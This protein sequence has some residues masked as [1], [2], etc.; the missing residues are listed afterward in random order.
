MVIPDKSKSIKEGVI[1][2]WAKKSSN[3]YEQ[4]WSA[5]CAYYGIDPKV[6]FEELS[7]E[8]SRTCCC[9]VAMSAFRF[10]TR[11]TSDG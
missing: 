11:T 6:P 1:D 9:T 3:Y 10:A 8:A 4:F 2:P 7:D 5:V